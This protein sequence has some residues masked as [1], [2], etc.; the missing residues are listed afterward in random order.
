MNATGDQVW[1]FQGSHLEN[2]QHREDGLQAKL[3]N[4]L[5]RKSPLAIVRTNG[6][7]ESH[8]ENGQH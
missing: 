7:Q 2:G 4:D 5:L 1:L 6:D 8:L 3:A